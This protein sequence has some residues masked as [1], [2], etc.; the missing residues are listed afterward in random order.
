MRFD[1]RDLPDDDWEHFLRARDLAQL[2]EESPKPLQGPVLEV[3]CGDGFLTGLLRRRF[4]MVVPIDIRPRAR[5]SGACVADA[6][7]LPFRDNA[8]QLIFSSNVLEHVKD[9]TTCMAEMRRVLRDDGLMVHTMPTVTWKVAQLVL[10][11]LHVL[12]HVAAPKAVGKLARHRQAVQTSSR[13]S[14]HSREAATVRRSRLRSLFMPPVHGA[15]SSHRRELRC[16]RKR[17]WVEQ[18]ELSGLEVVKTSPMFLHSAYRFL[19]YRALDL[20]GTMSR[21]GLASV[22]AYWVRK[23]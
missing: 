13:T 23:S 20:R 9:P 22:R 2:I 14:P 4:E 21:F 3:G 6:Q 8:F 10:Y 17:S 12:I 16:F 18:F 11:P 7:T 5:V 19:P 1:R 15:A